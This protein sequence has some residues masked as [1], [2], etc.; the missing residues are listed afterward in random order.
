MRSLILAAAALIGVTGATAATAQM[1]VKQT[2]TVTT[3]AGTT[4][5]TT[6]THVD[7]MSGRTDQRVTTRTKTAVATRHGH[8]AVASASRH[9]KTW[10]KHGRR[11]RSCKSVTRV[12]HLG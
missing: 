2:T 9:C 8:T 10:W 12:R 7:G 11:M 6:R 5:T 1:P 3:P 4:K